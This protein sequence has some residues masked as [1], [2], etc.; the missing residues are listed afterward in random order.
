MQLLTEVVR[1]TARQDWGRWGCEARHFGLKV[2]FAVASWVL[3]CQVD[4]RAL[5]L[6]RVPLGPT[7]SLYGIKVLVLDLQA[8]IGG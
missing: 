6:G 8:C 2:L 7:L 3:W 4:M 1:T 5:L